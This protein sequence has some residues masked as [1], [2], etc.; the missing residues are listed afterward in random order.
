M[1]RFEYGSFSQVTSGQ[2]GSGIQHHQK[3]RRKLRKGNYNILV[4]I[5]DNC[6]LV[7]RVSQIFFFFLCNS[8]NL[9]EVL[10]TNNN[11]K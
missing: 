7:L 4:K 8:K 1:Y 2:V 11:Y 9:Y 3:E 10:V 6:T 5:K